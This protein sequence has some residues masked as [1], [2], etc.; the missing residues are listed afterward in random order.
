M[1]NIYI[2][3]DCKCHV[4]N[5]DGIYVE[6]ESPEQF[7]GK[8]RTYIEGFRVRPEGYTYVRKDGIVFGPNGYEI[9]PWRNLEFLEEFQAEYEE[10]LAET[11]Q[12]KM[13]NGNMKEALAELGVTEDD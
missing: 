12:L 11:E 10:H 8:C 7:E 5:P 6:I 1:K 4:S 13:E 2:D 9:S 3:N